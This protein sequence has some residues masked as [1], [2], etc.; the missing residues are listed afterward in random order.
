MLAAAEGLF[1]ARGFH[2]ATLGQIAGAA[3]VSVGTLYNYFGGKRGLYLASVERALDANRRYM[4]LAFQSPL[5]P[6]D[7][8]LAAGDAYLRFHLDH[9]GYFQLIALPDIAESGPDEVTR[10]IA[11]TVESEVGRVEDA[12]R[13]AI[14]AGE[15]I[16]I[17]P[18]RASTFLWGAW[19][20]V[21]AAA[22]RPDRLRLSDHELGAVL[23]EGRRLVLQG[24][25]GPAMRRSDGRLRADVAFPRVDPRE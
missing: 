5:S 7:Q 17:D 9:P 15:A 10:R 11:D 4:D 23:D 19:N 20:G 22:A 25:A 2:R 8:L 16:P 1:R 3:D 21:I 14:E 18:R 12:I 13:R 6:V 24:L